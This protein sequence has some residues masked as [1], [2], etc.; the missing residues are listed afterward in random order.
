MHD[1]ERNKPA[2]APQNAARVRTPS[3]TIPLPS[4]QLQNLSR[5]NLPDISPLDG[6][7]PVAS[8]PTQDEASVLIPFPS[9]A[10]RS[11]VLDLQ[12][13]AHA[14]FQRASPNRPNR[15]EVGVRRTRTVAEAPRYRM[16]ALYVP[17]NYQIFNHQR[18][19]SLEINR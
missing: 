2:N 10:P 12:S 6:T 4:Q 8:S 18:G 7:P 1:V 17:E 11:Q 16:V 5:P 9:P 15:H 13:T 3:I 19:Q 14:S